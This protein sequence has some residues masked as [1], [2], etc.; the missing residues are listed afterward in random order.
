[1]I[2]LVD[3]GNTRIKWAFIEDGKFST[4]D[5]RDYTEMTLAAILEEYWKDFPVL[6]HMVVACVSSKKV[7]SI[8][9]AWAKK[10]N[11]TACYFLAPQKQF[12]SL[13]NGYQQFR[14]LGI[15]RW[16]TLV[17]AY[18]EY[19][20]P[21]VIFDCGTAMTV[22]AVDATGQ[23]IGGLIVPGLELM[24]KSLAQN[25]EGCQVDSPQEHK[26]D[27]LLANNTH[28]AVTGGCLYAVATFIERL[29]D[30]LKE[31]LGKNLICILTGG[32]A[33]TLLPLLH[34]SMK[35]EPHLVLK[36]LAVRVAVNQ[37]SQQAKA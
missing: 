22:D 37:Q 19:A 29:A 1:M 35:H 30:E 34:T 33:T 9:R 5:A 3:I 21:F 36:G 16:M 2:L 6:N 4:G 14:Q 25:T 24:R 12:E 28:Q 26:P 8:L 17:A 18:R 13:V 10:N 23:H 11:D 20:R 32:D 27:S 7:A 15:D 31:A